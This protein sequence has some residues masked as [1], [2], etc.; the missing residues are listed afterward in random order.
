MLQ[1]EMVLSPMM[2]HL[3]STVPLS[4]MRFVFMHSALMLVTNDNLI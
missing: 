4:P 3:Q 2:I 1:V